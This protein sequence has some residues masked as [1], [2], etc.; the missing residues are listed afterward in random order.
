MQFPNG[1]FPGPTILAA[2]KKCPETPESRQQ[3]ALLPQWCSRQVRGAEWPRRL[4]VRIP[5]QRPL[6]KRWQRPRSTT[7]SPY[8]QT[9]TASPGTGP[10]LA[11]ASWRKIRTDLE[12]GGKVRP[13]LTLKKLRH[14]VATVLAEMGSDERTIADLLGQKTTQMARNY[15]RSADTQPEDGGRGSPTRRRSEQTAHKNCQT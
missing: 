10:A 13:G 2:V 12:N 11:F 9:V 1:H 7:P 3:P 14:T 15:S 6:L 5:Y 4:K 8:A